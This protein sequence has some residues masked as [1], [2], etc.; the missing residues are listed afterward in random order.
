MNSV[1]KSSSS[2]SSVSMPGL[3]VT[4]LRFPWNDINT[5]LRAGNIEAASSQTSPPGA[6]STG[7]TI[8]SNPLLKLLNK[9][10]DW[11]TI[12]LEVNSGDTGTYFNERSCLEK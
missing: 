1:T 10:V 2:S 12:A 11:T 4:A 6:P 5:F 7:G 9:N 3:I 8:I